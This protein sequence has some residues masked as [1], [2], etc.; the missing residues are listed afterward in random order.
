[1]RLPRPRRGEPCDGGS[2]LTMKPMNDRFAISEFFEALL[3]CRE[4]Q[5]RRYERE[6]SPGLRA[7]AESYERRKREAQRKRAA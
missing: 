4:E 1:M 2:H 5:P 7:A 6:V 3:M